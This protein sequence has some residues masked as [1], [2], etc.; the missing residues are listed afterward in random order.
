MNLL[1][2][3]IPSLN[4]PKAARDALIHIL[5]SNL[6]S[7]NSILLVNN[8]SSQEY[9][10]AELQRKYGQEFRYIEFEENL[11]FGLNLIRLLEQCETKYLLFMSDEDDLNELGFNNLLFLL[12]TKKPP[13][14]ILRNNMNGIKSVYKLNQ[15]DVKGVSSYISGIIVNAD[16]LRE[17]KDMLKHLVQTEEFASLYPQV[18][19]STL[20]NSIQSGYIMKKPSITKRIELTTTVTSRNGSP[21]WYPS[22]RVHQHLSFQRCILELSK[23][24]DGNTEKQLKKLSKSLDSNFFG[25]IFDAIRTI[26][27]DLQQI[28]V[29]SSFKTIINFYFK[30][31]KKKIKRYISK[32]AED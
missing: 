13:L 18:I 17:Y 1:T 3:G 26:S 22:E 7:S 9:Q 20:L 11:G 16:I 31:S 8:G 29:R 15:N 32:I 4:R 21:Y 30:L 24:V 19:M 25:L 5:Q 10:I 27:P 14:V 23:N 2:I 12:S 28:L 6:L